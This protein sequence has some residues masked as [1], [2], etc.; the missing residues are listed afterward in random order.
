MRSIWRF[1]SH[2]PLTF[3]WL[4]LLLFTTWIQ[5]SVT[6]PRRHELLLHG[7]TNLHH[8]AGDPLQVLFASLLWIDGYYWWPYLL[9]FCLFLAPAEHWLGQFRWLAA[10]L[11]AHVVATYVSEGFLY[12]QIQEATASP[13]LINARDIGVSYFVVGMV[14][15]LSYHIVRPWRWLYL[16][17]A[18]L[19]VLIPLA[20]NLDFTPLGHSCALLVGLACYPLTRGRDSPAL[21]PTRRFRPDTQVARTRAPDA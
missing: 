2:A 4:A 6:G 21:D 17:A 13:V 18:M 1:V 14:G 19:T 15:I 12:L 16:G 10:G 7:S 9:V 5:H 11:I 8:L 3:S 20:I